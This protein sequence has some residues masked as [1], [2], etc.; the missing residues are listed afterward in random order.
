[1]KQKNLR[2][3]WVSLVLNFLSRY[4][5]TKIIIK[6]FVGAFLLANFIF[7]AP[8]NNSLFDLMSPFLTLAG[9]YTVITSTR[10]GFFAAGF[11]SGILWFYWI[12]FSF[13]YYDLGWL[14]PIVIL[15]IATIYGFIF[16][17]ASFPS[18]I[19]LRAVVLFV[20]SYIH[21]FGFNWFNLEATLVLGAFDPSARGLAFMFLAAI[22]LAYFS[23]IYKFIAVFICLVCALQFDSKDVKI[24]PFELQLTNSDI[25]QRQRW[26]KELKNSFINENLAVI[27]DA[28][29]NGKRAILMPESAFPTF[30]THESNLQTELKEKSQQIAIIAGGLAYENKQ[31]YNSAFFFDK[32]EMKRFDKLILVPFGEEIPLPNFIKEIINK[33]F[34]DGAQ[35]FQTAKTLSDYEIDGVKIRNAICYEATRDELYEG[36]FD[37]MFAITNNGWFKARYFPSTEPI[38]QRNLLKYY[39]T[40]Y[41]KTIYHSV[42]GSPSEIITPKKSLFN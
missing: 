12:S 7:L 9:I 21:P 31:I 11:F 39:A 25:L 17:A 10:A 1:M 15:S 34:F 40:K 14:I 22:S 24:L 3:A 33:M 19:T 23:K 18:F 41:N 8:F 42:N 26:D 35:D 29:N 13:I 5:S 30:I 28:I 6:A 27:D 2:F 37:V 20:F 36:K 4:F 32:G 38:L 16:W